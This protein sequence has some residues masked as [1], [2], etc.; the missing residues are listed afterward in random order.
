MLLGLFTLITAFL[1]ASKGKRKA[2]VSTSCSA[3]KAKKVKVLTRRLK[4][5]GTADVP[6]LTKRAEAAPLATETTPVMPI[7]ASADL[8]LIHISEP[9]RPY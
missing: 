9:T 8:S 4:P 7:E 1:S 6:K 2:V 3:P 5:I